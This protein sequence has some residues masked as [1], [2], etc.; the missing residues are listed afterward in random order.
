MR[1]IVTPNGGLRRPMLL[2]AA[3]LAIA[4][5][6]VAGA[7]GIPQIVHARQAHFKSLGRN[8]KALRDQIRQSHPNWGM[9]AADANR[10]ERLA[11]AL[12]TWFPAGSGKGHGVKTRARA[13]IWSN[14]RQFAQA[15]RIFLNRAQNLTQAAGGRDR[16]AL[17]LR[18]RELGQ[19]CGSCHRRFR[20]RRSWW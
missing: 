11:A 10:I 14:P 13:A 7:A 16:R 19:A 9:A 20:A 2:I 5:T 1:F 4:A 6:G 3:M 18:A 15:A 17:G 12:P 8:L